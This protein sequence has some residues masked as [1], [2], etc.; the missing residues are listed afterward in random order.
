MILNALSQPFSDFVLHYF[1]L[2][3]LVEQFCF[4][5]KCRIYTQKECNEIY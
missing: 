1:E 4:R 5:N 2:E 3:H